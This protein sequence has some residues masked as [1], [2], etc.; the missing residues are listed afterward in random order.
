LTVRNDG[1][2][3]QLLKRFQ[4]ATH[5]VLASER[6]EFRPNDTRHTKGFAHRWSRDHYDLDAEEFKY[7]SLV[8]PRKIICKE[9]ERISALHTFR[10]KIREAGKR[11]KLQTT[12]VPQEYRQPD[13]TSYMIK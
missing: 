12:D 6:V 4:Q 3:Q 2:P 11:L 7:K 8:Q 5:S 10:R 1:I 13:T 9:S